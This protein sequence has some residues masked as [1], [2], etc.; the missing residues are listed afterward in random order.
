MKIYGGICK[1]EGCPNK[2]FCKGFCL[3]HHN[4]RVRT[5]NP[6]TPDKI[7]KSGEGTICKLWGYK[8]ITINGKQVREHRYIMEKHLGRKLKPFPQEIVH[9]INGN[10]LDNR[11]EN[12]QVLYSGDHARMHTK[13]KPR[14]FASARKLSGLPPEVLIY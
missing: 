7:R 2:H 3:R 10:K 5:G 4:K 6:L 13:G 9:H 8:L 12:L 11:I 1:I 14:G